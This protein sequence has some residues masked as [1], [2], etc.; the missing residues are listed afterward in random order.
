[1]DFRVI[2]LSL[3][4]WLPS[5]WA[6]TTPSLTDLA[7]QVYPYPAQTLEQINNIERQRLPEFDE[8]LPR[9]Q[10]A[11]LKCETFV[12]QG[13]YEAALNLARMHEA[14]A[15]AKQLPQATPY[16]LNCMAAAFMQYG[17][18][19]QALPILD[20]AVLLSRE[21]Q[22]PQ[23]LVNA[24]LLRARI[25]IDTASYSSAL[26]DL[27]LATDI[28]PDT[29]RQATNWITPPK[30]YIDIAM[31]D[32]YALR[33]QTNQAYQLVLRALDQPQVVGKVRLAVTLSLARI[34][35]QNNQIANR[36]AFILEAKNLLPELG[37]AVELASSY[38]QLAE[39]EFARGNYK[40]AKQLL[41]LALNSFSKH[42]RTLGELTATR[43]LAQLAL[44]T[45]E[46]AKGLALMEQVLTQAQRSAKYE[47]LNIAFQIL[48]DYYAE[49]GDYEQAY[50][51]QLLRYDAASNAYNF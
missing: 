12:Q 1:M 44:A 46:E 19:R 22:Q 32:L 18:V 7:T 15:K 49:Q 10:L 13:E 36:D 34:A 23:S 47:Q 26:E 29:A 48:S 17:D 35:Q 28:Y 31:A 42:K 51:Y 43:S 25:D 6:N 21:Q 11:L 8:G 5:L 40:S 33:N 30:A 14:R 41:E 39:L 37:S 16:F 2:V 9:L 24:L 4:F 38:Q 45:G 3:V 27:R 20:K 50:D